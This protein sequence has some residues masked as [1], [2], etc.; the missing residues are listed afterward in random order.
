M[1]NQSEYQPIQLIRDLYMKNRSLV[2]DGFDES[3]DYIANIIPLNIMK[4]ETGSYAQT[5]KIPMKWNLTEASIKK[6]GQKIISTN[7]HPLHVYTCSQPFKGTVSKEELLEH[8]FTDE[9]RPDVI[10]YKFIFYKNDW[11]FCCAH[12]DLAL[13]DAESYEVDIDVEFTDGFLSLGEFEKKGKSDET[14][15]MIVHVDHPGQCNDN[16]S[17]VSVA[18]KLALYLAQLD[19][20]E[21]TYK[22]VFVP[23]T[24]GSM[25]YLDRN[26]EQLI[27]MKHGMVFDAIGHIN[28]MFMMKS[29]FHTSLMDRIAEHVFSHRYEDGDCHDFLDPKIS[30]FLNDERMMQSPGFDIPT[31]CFSRAPYQYYHSSADTPDKMSEDSLEDTFVLLIEIIN[32]FENNYVPIRNYDGTPFLSKYQLWNDDWSN[33]EV[34]AVEKLI[35]N[36]DNRQDVFSI[37]ERINAPFSFVFDFIEKMRSSGLVNKE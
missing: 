18:V 11:G 34:N 24:I 9:S 5:W 27:N 8:L 28:R 6:N 22:I 1:S 2:C 35:F 3:L 30:S 14:V 21:L 12:N 16:L 4:F 7:N 26:K 10:P 36:I 31:I 15:L 23:E 32:V 25:A 20:P 33:K 19:Q 13:F 29:R 17:G 37:A